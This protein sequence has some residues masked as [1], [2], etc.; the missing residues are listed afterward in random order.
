ML[1]LVLSLQRGF[2][3]DDKLI[4]IYTLV[5]CFSV[6][7]PRG[8]NFFWTIFLLRYKIYLKIKTL[9]TYLGP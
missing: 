9:Q 1:E 5:D 7:Y 2:F 4:P 8:T 3:Q 6:L